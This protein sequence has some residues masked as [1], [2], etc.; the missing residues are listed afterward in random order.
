MH[1]SKL[2]PRLLIV[3]GY[4]LEKYFQMFLLD[5]LSLNL[6][7]GGTLKLKTG[8]GGHSFGHEAKKPCNVY[9]YKAL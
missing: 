4:L 9:R 5:E 1:S 6:S 8:R 7:I 3:F 2:V